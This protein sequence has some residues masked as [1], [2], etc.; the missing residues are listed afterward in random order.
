MIRPNEA[1]FEETKDD[2]TKENNNGKN[3]DLCR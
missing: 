3:V 2:Q 1:K